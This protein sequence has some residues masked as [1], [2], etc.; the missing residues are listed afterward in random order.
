VAAQTIESRLGDS[1]RLGVGAIISPQSLTAVSGETIAIPDPERTTHL[2]LRRFV[3]CPICNLHLRSV[4][5]RHAE[6]TAAGLRE[7][8]AFHSSAA[9]LHRYAPKVPFALVGDP[10]RRLYRDF[11]VDASLLSLLHPRAWGAVV[12]GPLH[13]V[14]DGRGALPLRP[15]GGRLGLPADFLIGSDGRLLA[16]K[17]GAH[18]YDQWSIDELLAHVRRLGES[19]SAA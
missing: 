8:V 15:T 3:G 19:M 16:V 1:R 10:Q 2:Q 11:G 4:V 13:A 6:I 14:R 12:R 18:A 9:E 7:V 5:E 17:Y